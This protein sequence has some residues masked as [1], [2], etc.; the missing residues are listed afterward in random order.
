MVDDNLF[1]TPPDKGVSEPST[2]D[3]TKAPDK[4]ETA[5]TGISAEEVQAMIQPLQTQLETT[6]RDLA[7]SQESYRQLEVRQTAAD[8]PPQTPPTQDEFITKFTDDAQGT[9]QE[10]IDAGIQKGIAQVVPFLEQQNN[11]THD[12]LVAGHKATIDATYGSGTW[13]SEIEP[14]FSTQMRDLRKNNAQALSNPSTIDTAVRGIMGHKIDELST[15]KAG[16]ATSATEARDVEDQRIMDRFSNTAGMI[17]GGSPPANVSRELSDSEKD[18][19][20]SVRLSGRDMTK[21]DIQRLREAKGRDG[22]LK[23]YRAAQKSRS[24]GAVA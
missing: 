18:Y 22:T 19:M 11:T 5:P 6:T 2:S 24:N 14:L 21:S 10:M 23:S 13:E 15:R 1:D 4:S 7:A 17:G 20:A 3:I 9:V 12:G 16:L 8:N